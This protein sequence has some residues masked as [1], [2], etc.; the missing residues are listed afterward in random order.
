MIAGNS[1]WGKG[2]I[3]N[4]QNFFKITIISE[5]ES[6]SHISSFIFQ[7]VVNYIFFRRIK[8]V[9][10]FI[11]L[12]YFIFLVADFCWDVGDNPVVSSIG[13]P[14][15]LPHK[16]SGWMLELAAASARL[17]WEFCTPCV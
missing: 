1:S 6:P 10:S 13:V 5:K 17:C 3:L 16:R 4:A 8:F 11:Y 15:T 7:M 2:K 14:N 12:F 9:S